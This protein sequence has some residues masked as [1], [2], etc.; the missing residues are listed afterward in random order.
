[1]SEAPKNLNPEWK[2]IALR[3]AVKDEHGDVVSERRPLLPM[4]DKIPASQPN[5]LAASKTFWAGTR[6][7]WDDL[8]D[9]VDEQGFDIGFVP[10]LQNMVTLD[11]DVKEYLNETGHVAGPI[12]VGDLTV[13]KYG[14]Q[15]LQRVVEALG[16]GMQEI[17]T[18]TV[19][20][21]SGGLHLHY[22]QNP[23]Y[24]LYTCGHREDWRVDIVGMNNAS[25]RSWV[26]APPSAG[27][28]VVRDLPVAV[29]P[30][31]LAQWLRGIKQHLQPLGGQRRQAQKQRIE[32]LNL[33]RRTYGRNDPD[34]IPTTKQWVQMLLDL[35]T[36]ANQVGG[37]NLQI[38][39][40]SKDLL[41]F[42]MDP[43]VVRRLVLQYAAPWTT[44]EWHKA[45]TTI[46]SAENAAQNT[47]GGR[48]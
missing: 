36:D 4:P 31:W 42:G 8:H 47:N 21:K 34:A 28:T 38:W 29:M 24:P 48:K 26:A 3:R 20:T 7:D 5:T 13:K 46:K 12:R 32:E 37:W 23:D 14:I 25:N 18:Y 22:L 17:A 1:M 45:L 33:E 44:R 27:Y 6:L 35:I 15:D 16:H 30:D 19:A 11:C 39:Q 9:V 43:V 2:Y 41:E 10:A 40:T